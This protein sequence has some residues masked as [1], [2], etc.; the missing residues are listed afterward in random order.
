MASSLRV[1]KQKFHAYAFST[2]PV[3]ATCATHLIL[4]DLIILNTTKNTN[5]KLLFTQLMG[6][7]NWINLAH[8]TDPCG[9]VNEPSGYVNFCVILDYLS[10]C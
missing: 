7:M 4:F 5:T 2:S 1:L 9:H 8:D 3:Q 10:D 6:G